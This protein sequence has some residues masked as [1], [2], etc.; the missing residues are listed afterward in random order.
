MLVCVG[1]YLPLETTFAIFLGGV[2]KGFTDW[3]VLKRR[4]PSEA[5]FAS[6]ENVGVLLASGL[7]AGEALMGLVIAMFAVGNIFLYDVFSFFSNP[8]VTISV[9]MLLLIAYVLVRY[10]LTSVKK[11]K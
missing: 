8:P 5:A 11:E 9:I 6:A 7:I 4:N 3:L 1:M 2:I 10:P